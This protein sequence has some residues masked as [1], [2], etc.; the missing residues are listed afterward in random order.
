MTIPTIFI[1]YSHKDEEWKDRLVTH[2]GVLQHEGILE[3]WDDR[4]I[5]GSEDWYQK[6]EQAINTASVAILMISANFLTSNFILKEE[7]PKLFERREKE[8]LRIFPIIVKPCAWQQVK[9]LPRI[10]ARPKDGR[11]LS[12]GNAHQIDTDLAA[13]TEE[14]AAILKPAGTATS[15][16]YMPLGPDKIY[17]AKLPSTSLDLFGRE[18]E[19]IAFDK[20][21]GDPKINV[22]SL[23]AWGGV[24]KTSL[25]NKWLEKIRKN[26]WCGAERVYG[27]SFYSQGAAESRQV[28]ADPFIAAALKWFGAP[29]MAD[30]S[31]SSWDK[32]ERLAELLKQQRTLLILD[33]LEPLQNPS[34]SGAGEIRDRTSGL[35]ALL[36]ELAQQNPG[37]VIL[38]TR[39][40]VDD[41]KD[42]A[43]SSSTEIDLD[44]LSPEAGAQ[45]LKYLGVSSSE[46]ELKQ[47]SKEFDGHALALTLLGGYLKVVCGGDVR[48]RDKIER[49]T[50]EKRQGAHAR[51]VMES[52]E[53]WL[54]GK[55]ELDI[56]RLIG[57]FD[58][59]AELGAMNA[60]KKEPAIEGLTTRLQGLNHADWQYTIDNLRALRLISTPVQNNSDTLDCHPLIREHFGEKLKASNSDAWKEAHSRLY[61]YYKTSAKKLPD[62]IEE[63]A[64]LYAAV[65]HGCQAERHQEALDEVYS[66]RIQ[67]GQEFYDLKKLGAFGAELS[68]LSGFFDQVWCK[69]V[70]CLIEERKGFVLNNA[71]ACLH[72]LGRIA[73]STQPGW[74]ALETAISLKLW[75]KAST[76]ALNLSQVYVALGD[77]Q[78]ALD[79]ASQSIEFADRSSYWDK[80]MFSHAILAH[81]LHQTGRLAEADTFFCKAEEIQKRN[82][83][84][85]ALYSSPGFHYCDLLLDQDNYHE[86]QNRAEKALKIVLRGSQSLIDIALNNLSLG[87]AHLIRAQ[88]V[89]AAMGMEKSARI[90]SEAETYLDHAVDGLRQAGIQ[91]QIPP[92]LLAR[93]ELRRVTDKLDKAKQDLAEAFSITTRCGMRLFETDCHLEYARWY[94][95]NSEKDKAREH[96]AIAKKMVDEIGYHRRDKEVQ[97]LEAKL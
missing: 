93:A 4:R 58:R 87:R 62:T 67:R 18:N 79:Y 31:T 19:L 11:P 55:P 25:V 57:L 6:I 52:Y 12:G 3:T 39:L 74:A 45:Y 21:W 10:Q 82:Q 53:R 2:L 35:V 81:V 77:L 36:R 61:E 13:I 49:L 40:P 65:M 46:D 33:G 34:L 29:E 30:S 91:S 9:W 32:G 24:G 16:D 42:F 26:N 71:G 70:D 27:W 84:K 5:G 1:S 38:T 72:A 54:E 44:N 17:L 43:G 89:R 76:A 75:N 41:L 69:P 68:V 73:E 88:K 94:L 78:Q 66:K 8:G 83:P 97:E 63:M 92:G 37:L 59:P 14:I 51:R 28:S 47:A 22:L 50:D 85:T 64:P 90:Y 86:V 56:L 60:L 23:I 96:F 15:T 20:A 48:Q 95:A 7:I 80:Q